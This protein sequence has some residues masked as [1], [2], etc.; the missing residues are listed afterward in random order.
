MMAL[1]TV[2][3]DAAEF[4]DTPEM[5]AA[6]LADVFADGDDAEIK[7]ALATIARAKGMANE[8][9]S[10]SRPTAQSDPSRCDG[11]VIG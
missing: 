9:A 8:K 3:F 7:L 6:Y 11:G 2:K 1:N 4:L 10:S 5:Q